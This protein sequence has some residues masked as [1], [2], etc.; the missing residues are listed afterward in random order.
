MSPDEISQKNPDL[1]H[2]A[3]TLSLKRPTLTARAWKA[4][5]LVLAGHV[6]PARGDFEIACVQGSGR[7]ITYSIHTDDD[8][9]DQLICTC[10]D[11]PHAPAGPFSWRWC[12]HM[13]AWSMTNQLQKQSV[14]IAHL[15]PLVEPEQQDLNPLFIPAL[16]GEPAHV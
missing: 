11:H 4:C 3:R 5:E 16:Q 7:N 9:P 15:P 1:A 8:Q 10:L 14:Q 12:K 6:F 2:L 13:I